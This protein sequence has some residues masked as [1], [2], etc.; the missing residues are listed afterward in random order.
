MIIIVATLVYSHDSISGCQ[1]KGHRALKLLAVGEEHDVVE[2]AKDR[3]D[4]GYG[5]EA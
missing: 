5:D 2:Q 3:H 1:A 4:K